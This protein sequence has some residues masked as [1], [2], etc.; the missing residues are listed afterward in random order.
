MKQNATEKTGAEFVSLKDIQGSTDVEAGAGTVV[1]D[2]AGNPHTVENAD[3][4]AH[5]G[6][7]GMQVIADR[8]IEALQADEVNR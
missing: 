6:D 4:A 1:Y 3:V 2:P 8:I 5:P 7:R